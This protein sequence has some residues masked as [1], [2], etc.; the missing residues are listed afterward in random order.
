MRISDWSSDVCS[1]DLSVR[2]WHAPLPGYPAVRVA[3]GC[4]VV[5]MV[6]DAMVAHSPAAVGREIITGDRIRG[7]ACFS[8]Q[9]IF[10]S[11]V[12]K[13]TAVQEIFTDAETQGR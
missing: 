8:F 4:L 9:V 3:A 6:V 2:L 10:R 11:N 13:G 12:G 7:Q 5:G 1:S